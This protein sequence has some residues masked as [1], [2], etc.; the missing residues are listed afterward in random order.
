MKSEIGIV[1]GGFDRRDD[2]GNAV[3]LFG[4]SN[5]SD[6]K[7]PLTAKPRH[8]D[9]RTTTINA[10]GKAML[11]TLGVWSHLKKSLFPWPASWLLKDRSRQSE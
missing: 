5:T 3:A 11:E 2:G 8:D 10:A 6:K 7:A 4:Y 1:G 9:N